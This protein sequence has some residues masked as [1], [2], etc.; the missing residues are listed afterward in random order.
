MDSFTVRSCETQGD[1]LRTAEFLQQIFGHG[2]N[3][4][5]THPDVERPLSVRYVEH[6]GAIVS[7]HVLEHM[8]LSF[9][10]DWVSAVR[11]ELVGTAPSFRRQG[12]C[13]EL[14]DNSLELERKRGTQLALVFG[15]PLFRRLGFEYCIPT[16]EQGMPEYSPPGS[17]VISARALSSFKEPHSLRPMTPGNLP[18]VEEL[19]SSE[20]P[21]GNLSR[22]RSNEYWR[23]LVQQHGIDTYHVCENKGTVSGY[24][25]IDSAKGSVQA[26][27]AIA[28]DDAACESILH[29]LRGVAEVNKA[30][31]VVFHCPHSGTLG[32]YL[33]L[34]GAAEYAVYAERETN[35]QVRFLDFS[36]CL[37]M[38]Q[39]QFSQRI[40]GSEFASSE[41]VPKNWALV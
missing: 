35:V 14:I 6:D 36:S 15:Y 38:L 8:Q 22:R 29:H 16:Y 40:Q 27:E 25:R 2:R 19:H 23:Y 4:V 10:E 12:L 41:R 39:G 3:Y 37:R 5:L 26:R 31:A 20:N 30:E 28:T 33:R 13:R 34:R 17:A 24:V 1:V 7:A 11:V 9:G 21:S 18:R 32:S